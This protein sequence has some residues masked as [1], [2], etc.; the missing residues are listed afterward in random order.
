M[1]DDLRSVPMNLDVLINTEN[2]EAL[3]SAHSVAQMIRNIADAHRERPL[4]ADD[5]ERVAEAL[6][7]E[8]LSAVVTHREKQGGESQA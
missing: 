5:M 2:G 3:F 6:D 4:S 1:S 8:I 7:M